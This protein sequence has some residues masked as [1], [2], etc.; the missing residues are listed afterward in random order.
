MPMSSEELMSAMLDGECTPAEMDQ[1]LGAIEADPALMARWSR[2]CMPRDALADTRVRSATPDFCAGVMAA[3]R[4]DEPATSSKVVP[5]RRPAAAPPVVRPAVRASRWQPMAGVAAAA[6]IA[7]VAAV[8]GYRWL[9]QPLNPGVAGPAVAA[10][11]SVAATPVAA[12]QPASLGGAGQGRLVAVSAS[13]AEPVE[14]RWSQLDADTAR[15]LNEFMMEH[16]NLRAEQGM[17]SALSYPRMV[18]TVD[19]RSGGEPH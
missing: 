8:G 1:L 18:R 5:L 10:N 14:T 4:Q 9:N 2:L 19:Y 12:V 3:I 17:G 7:A 11:S 16:S 15:Q 13:G 6:S